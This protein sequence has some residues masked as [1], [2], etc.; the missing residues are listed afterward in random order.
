[1][2]YQALFEPEEESVVISFPDFGY[3]VSQAEGESEAMRMAT[4]LLICLITDCIKKGEPLP[5]RRKHKGKHYKQVR[6]PA[7]VGAKVELYREFLASGIRKTELAART[8]L[9]KTNIDRLFDLRR[10]TRF[11]LIEAAFAAI[12]KRLLID[13]HEA[14]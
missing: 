6:L 10:S 11:E 3:G 8:G 1:M 7:L 12:G 4:D 13:V 2:E 9:A 14:A 5:E